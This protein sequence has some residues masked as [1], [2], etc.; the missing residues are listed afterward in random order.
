MYEPRNTTFYIRFN[1]SATSSRNIVRALIDELREYVVGIYMSGR[2]SGVMIAKSWNEVLV[3]SIDVSVV[4]E[5]V[6]TIRKEV[7]DEED[8]DEYIEFTKRKIADLNIE[9]LSA[10]EDNMNI[11]IYGKWF[12]YMIDGWLVVLAD[13]RRDR[14]F[15]YPILRKLSRV[16]IHF[17]PSIVRS[18]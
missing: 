11:Y 5:L 18:M 7:D 14:T 10:H 13:P 6:D 4:S 3:L 15:E 12:R 16:G 1:L 2:G 9:V 17:R 8:I